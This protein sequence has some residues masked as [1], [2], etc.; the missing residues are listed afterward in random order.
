MIKQTRIIDNSTGE[1]VKDNVQHIAAAFD[2]EKGY[3]FWARKGFA[4]SFLD[5]EFPTEMSFKKR[6]QMATLA[7]RMWSKTNMRRVS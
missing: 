2:D 4:K 3:L 1:V 5:I 6:G 7:K